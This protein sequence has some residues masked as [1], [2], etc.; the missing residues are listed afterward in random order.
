MDSNDT[1]H[2]Y[3]QSFHFSMPTGGMPRSRWWML[4]SWWGG[5][6]YDVRLWLADRISPY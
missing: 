3:Y 1:N 4:K 6:V 5:K 2:N